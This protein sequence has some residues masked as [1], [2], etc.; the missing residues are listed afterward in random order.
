MRLGLHSALLEGAGFR[1]AFFMRRGGVS[2]KPWKSLNF[3]SASGDDPEHVAA[4][5]ERAAGELGSVA[6]QIYYLSQVH[7]TAHRVL[8]GGEDQAE[9]IAVEG[10][11]TLSATPGVTCAVRMADCAAV[12]M[13]DRQSGAVVAVHSGWRGTVQGAVANGVQALRELIGAA[14]DIVA[15]VGPHIEACCFEVG[16]DVADEIAAVSELGQSI[17]DRTRA[18]PHVDLRRLIDWQLV[19][20]GVQA[21]DHVRGCTM[22]DAVRFHSYRRE[23]KRSGRM[24]AAVVARQLSSSRG[25]ASG[26]PR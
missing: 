22:C 20:S 21:V 17:V 15:T 18:R 7:G 11:I 1:H 24:L 2:P 25:V 12:L 19:R 8:D 6:E 3:S 4:N 5:I 10:D 26:S 13:G 9:V 14:G 23:G 16:P